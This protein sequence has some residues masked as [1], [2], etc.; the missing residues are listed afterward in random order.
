M[1]RFS[2]DLGEFYNFKY[3]HL[4]FCLML[5]VAMHL[6][7]FHKAKD[8]QWVFRGLFAG[9][10]LDMTPGFREEFS[11]RG[12]KK[13]SMKIMSEREVWQ[14]R[15]VIIIFTKS[16]RLVIVFFKKG[17]RVFFFSQKSACPF[18]RPAQHTL[19][20]NIPLPYDTSRLSISMA[21]S[22]VSKTPQ[23]KSPEEFPVK[24][25]HQWWFSN[26]SKNFHRIIVPWW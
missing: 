18:C 26:F 3:E 13:V 1:S 16:F 15:S 2:E 11:D 5:I 21:S 17:F 24:L 10:S 7:H 14:K 19:Q 4:I 23:G 20:K 6:S 8:T 25:G 12:D 22:P 9:V